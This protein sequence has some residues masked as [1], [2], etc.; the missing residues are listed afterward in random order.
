MYDHVIVLLALD[1]VFEII[2]SLEKYPRMVLHQS[3]SCPA[4]YGLLILS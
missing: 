3:K 4:F 1:H 2:T